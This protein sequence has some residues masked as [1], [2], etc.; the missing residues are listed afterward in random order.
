MCHITL[1]HTCTE[2]EAGN[3]SSDL[4]NPPYLNMNYDVLHYTAII[5]LYVPLDTSISP[6]ELCLLQFDL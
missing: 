1:C 4:I 5:Q 2:Q 3:L 6:Q